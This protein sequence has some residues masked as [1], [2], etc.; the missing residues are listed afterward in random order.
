MKKTRV[1][2]LA[3][4]FH[5]DT[6]EL[7]DLLAELE[8]E[9]VSHASSLSEEEAERVREKLLAAQTHQISQKR[10]SRK[11]IRRRKKA[12]KVPE[13]TEAEP[14]EGEAVEVRPDVGAPSAEIPVM[15]AQET[16]SGVVS[17]ASEE[18]AAE[19]ESSQEVLVEET[20]QDAPAP[21]PREKPA[22][23]VMTAPEEDEAAQEAAPSEPEAPVPPASPEEP[24]APE[25]EPIRETAEVPPQPEATP[26]QDEAPAKAAAEEE[27]EAPAP[28]EPPAKK[29]ARTEAKAKAKKPTA[30]KAEKPGEDKDDVS[31]EAEG[32]PLHQDKKV[33]RLRW[34][35]GEPARIIS[36]PSVPPP[37]IKPQAPQRTPVIDGPGP[38]D[39]P[40][41][42]KDDGVRRRKGKAA[43]KK[44]RKRDVGRAELYSKQGGQFRG[45]KSKRSGKKAQKTQITQPKAI[46]MRIKVADAITVADLAKRMGVKA[47]DVVKQLLQLGMMVSLNQ[48]LDLETATIVGTEFGYEIE[49]SSFEESDFLQ[50]AEDRDENLQPRPPVVTIMGHVDHGKSSLLEAISTREINIVDGEAGGITQH[51]GAY[52]VDVGGSQIVFLDTPGHEAFTAM[53][54][55]GAQVTDIVVLVVAADDG[56]MDQT[57]EAINHSQAAKVPIIVAVNKI[58]KPDIDP[59]RVKR[60]LSEAG[61]QPE[62]WG[63]DTIFVPVSAKTGQGIDDLLEAIKLQAEMQELMGDPVKPATG[64]VVEAQI[65]RG[66]GTVAT[67]LVQGGTLKVGDA[68]V[69]GS[70]H[71][72]V[73]ALIDDKG[74]P[75]DEAGPSTP[76]QVQGLSGVPEAGDEF[77][78][79]ADDKV[80]RQVADHRASKRRETELSQGT[81]VSL[82]SLMAGAGEEVKELNIVLRADVQGSIEALKDSLEKLSTD[83]VKLSVIQTGTGAIT[84]SDIMLASASQAVVLGFNVRA[85]AK[86]NEVAEQERIEI[87]Y[88]DV[89]YKAIEEIRE[90]MAGLLDSIYKE[91]VVGRAEVREVFR[92]PKL[93]AVAGSHVQDGNIRR[94]GLVR[95]VRDG[96]VVYDGKISSLRRFKDDVKEVAAGYEC[97]IGLENFNDIKVGDVLEAYEMEE[98]R[99]ELDEVN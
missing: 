16:L 9:A 60:E 48:T 49:R 58:D 50:V 72:K 78:V 8:I 62:D 53:R 47:T 28:V 35:D 46:K 39:V 96:V 6:R 21:E 22:E 30:K 66:R 64:R 34:T 70:H 63:G 68:F 54:A 83:K 86:V 3:K 37:S 82:E 31:S 65:D 92:V 59:D 90:A 42:E 24:Q 29:T 43:K 61:L 76:V 45:S 26:V 88:Y 25:P 89:I 99:P 57:K 27:T 56:V 23:P 77:Q 51:I 38:I 80:A 79:V 44:G 55:R 14:R 19:A 69:V 7:L 4:E 81:R 2:E 32:K 40:P 93:G 98:I 20:E 97:G 71:G 5:K 11:V 10:I 15:E 95:L 87:R 52:K 84:E 85:N 74:N 17:T 36:R 41:G 75:V 33:K 12:I 18:P 73:R 67:V 13:V 94:G 91:H 1:Y